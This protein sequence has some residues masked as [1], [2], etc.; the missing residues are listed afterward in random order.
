[1]AVQSDAEIKGYIS[2]SL[3]GGVIQVELTEDQLNDSVYEAK[4]W[5]MGNLGQFKNKILNISPNGGYVDVAEDCL[6]VVDVYFDIERSDLFDQFDWAGVEVNPLAIGGY[7]AYYGGMVGMGGGYSFLVQS[8]QYRETARRV[9]GTDR[10]WEWDSNDRKLRLYP[11]SGTNIGTA[12]FVVY[13]TDDI[14]LSKTRPYEYRIIRK[15]AYATAM[16][17]L[18]QIRSKYAE[19]PSATGSIALNG[20]DLIGNA[21]IMRENLKQ[22]I[23]LLR[24][25][26]NFFT[27]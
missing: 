6:S 20:A 21:D 2:R 22:E 4:M 18:G 27:G 7:G 23:M 9:L 17:T 11:T 13:M 14:D 26:T 3:G 5:F 16:E 19:G 12:V 1:M 8:M 24:P 15:Y 25:P 10:D